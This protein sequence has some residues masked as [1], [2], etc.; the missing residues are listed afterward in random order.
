MYIAHSYFNWYLKPVRYI[1][2][3]QVKVYIAKGKKKYKSLWVSR[4]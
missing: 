4:R 3:M 1:G 2:G